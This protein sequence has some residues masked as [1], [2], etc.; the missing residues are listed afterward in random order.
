MNFSSIRLQT[1]RFHIV[2]KIYW[3]ISNISLCTTYIGVENPKCGPCVRYT[4]GGVY[5]QYSCLDACTY[6]GYCQSSWWPTY[7][8]CCCD[9]GSTVCNWWWGSNSNSK[10]RKL[11][12]KWKL[13]YF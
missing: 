13:I 4:G 10:D 3:S 6:G 8:L 5:D 12:Q 9:C 11:E 2:M 1:L 7:G